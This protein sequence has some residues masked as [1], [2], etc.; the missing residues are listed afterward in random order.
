MGD[1]PIEFQKFSFFVIF[2]MLTLI[3]ARECLYRSRCIAGGGF[4][5][6][7]LKE[8]VVRVGSI[9]AAEITNGLPESNNAFIWKSSHENFENSDDRLISFSLLTGMND[10]KHIGCKKR[11]DDFSPS[12]G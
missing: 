3:T 5:F 9:K 12:Q 7:S 10:Q 8:W 4:K 2:S 11:P 6:L 1:N